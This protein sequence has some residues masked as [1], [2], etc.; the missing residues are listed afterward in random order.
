MRKEKAYIIASS[1][2]LCYEFPKGLIDKDESEVIDFIRDNKWEP[3]ETWE[4]HGI[5]NLIEDLAEDFLNFS[6]R[7]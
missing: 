2:F 1:H 6:K 5:W 3:F 7:D 4:P